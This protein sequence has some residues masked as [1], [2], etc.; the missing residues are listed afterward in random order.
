MS[1]ALPLHG[2]SARHRPAD[3]STPPE[4]DLARRSAGAPMPLVIIG[5]LVLLGGAAYVLFALT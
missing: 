5:V 4:R 1:H 2:R 3:R